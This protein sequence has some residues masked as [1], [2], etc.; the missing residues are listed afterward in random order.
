MGP[1]VLARLAVALAALAAVAAVLGRYG[2]ADL[3]ALGHPR[4]GADEQVVALGTLAAWACLARLAYALLA[5]ACRLRAP[6]GFSRRLAG[7]VLGIS[8]AAATGL[9]AGVLAAAP[10]VADGPR[11]P[12]GPAGPFDR[13]VP[14]SAPATPPLT[15][16]R[17]GDTLWGIAA[18]A[19]GIRAGPAVVAAAWPRW[20]AANH[21][22]I[23]PDPDLVLPG[24]RLVPPAADP[25]GTS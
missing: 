22:V 15:V 3:A 4:T 23:G 11:D 13:P 8:T 17:P 25:G 6:D 14:A 21:S 18:R 1:R 24:L 5:V 16:V 9:A 7:R 12:Y 2:H 20:Y 19:A 10:A